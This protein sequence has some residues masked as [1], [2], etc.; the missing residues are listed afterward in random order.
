MTGFVVQ[1]FLRFKLE[2]KMYFESIEFSKDLKATMAL[3]K[4]LA[5]TL[6]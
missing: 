3:L 5:L 1:G 2:I 4:D 6:D